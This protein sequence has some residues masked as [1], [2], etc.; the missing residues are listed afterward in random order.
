MISVES[1]ATFDTAGHDAIP[2]VTQH[3]TAITPPGVFT[4][5]GAA[6]MVSLDSV[7]PPSAD[8]RVESC[9]VVLPPTLQRAVPIRVRGFVGGRHCAATALRAAG[10]DA[11]DLVGPLPIGAM[12]APQWPEGWMGSIT[13]SPGFAAAVACPRGVWRGIGIDCERLMSDAAADGIAERVIPEAGAVQLAGQVGAA[14]P[15]GSF[16]T[17]V[18]SAKESVYKCL[19]PT[20]GTFFGFEVC[21]LVAIDPHAGT[22]TLRLVESPG[23]GVPAGLELRAAF[24]LA[25]GHVF[26][27]VGW[28][29]TPRGSGRTE[30]QP[31][32]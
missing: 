8:P 19:N 13:H 26:T 15:W 4:A 16:V 3:F 29:P 25:R 24:H 12:G 30:D 18:F 27:A 11:M 32:P 5:F 9:T 10:I 28:L 20:C 31:D 17:A 14:L 22:M 6:H 7:D 23:P 21:H 2:P 1:R